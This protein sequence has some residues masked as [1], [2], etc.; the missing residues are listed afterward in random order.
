MS[1]DVVPIELIESKIYVFRGKNVMIDRDL[2]TLY[3]VE[4]RVLNQAV[5]RNVQRFPEDFMF[6]LT[7]Q[8]SQNLRSQI[9]IS[10]L[11]YGG[12]RYSPYVFTEQGVAM[13]SSVLKSDRAIQVNIQIMRTFT[14]MREML[15]ENEELRRKIELLE[16]QYDEKFVMVFDAIRRLIDEPSKDEKEI[17]FK[18]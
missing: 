10:S 8:E 12:R 7:D 17:G 18:Y 5:R 3:G 4:T 2:A 9:V 15:T 11:E 14:R 16:K 13:L 1:T 6:Q